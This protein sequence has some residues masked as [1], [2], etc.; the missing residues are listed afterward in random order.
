[1]FLSHTTGSNGYS[2]ALLSVIAL[3]LW[4][5]LS[6][7]EIGK[8]HRIQAVTAIHNH[9]C[10]QKKSGKKGDDYLCLKSMIYDCPF[11]QEMGS[12]IKDQIHCIQREDGKHYH[13]DQ[14]TV[15]TG[16]TQNEAWWEE[17]EEEF[18]LLKAVCCIQNAPHEELKKMFTM[19]KKE[20]PFQVLLYSYLLV[21]T[22]IKTRRGHGW[23]AKGHFG[24]KEAQINVKVQPVPSV[25]TTQRQNKKDIY[26]CAFPSKCGCFRK[27]VSC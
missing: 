14:E 9:L 2:S 25:Y 27:S 21:L 1:M 24:S 17:K 10:I 20:V 22:W 5:A 13:K 8:A 15:R 18:S 26:L 3:L 7:P 16:L 6:A 19:L 12:T 11:Q 4:R 23:R